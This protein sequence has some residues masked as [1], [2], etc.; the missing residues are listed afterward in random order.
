MPSEVQV[1]LNL[2]YTQK[3]WTIQARGMFSLRGM[4][5]ISG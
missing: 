1:A 5:E 3:L 4:A 2:S